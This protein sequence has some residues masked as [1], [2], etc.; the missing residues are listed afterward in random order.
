M[1]TLAVVLA[2]CGSGGTPSTT[3]STKTVTL[4]QTE[5]GDPLPKLDRGWVAVRSRSGGFILGRPPG[6]KP[7][8]SGSSLTLIAP[9]KL[10][11]VTVS[12]DRTPSGLAI[13]TRSF[14]TRTA[15]SL[16]GYKGKLEPSKPRPFR[17]R[18]AA[19]QVVE[20]ARSRD[21]VPQELRVVVM[22]RPRL[23][24]FSAVIARNAKR[25]DAAEAEQAIEIV[26]TVRSRPDNS[27]KSDKPAKRQR[28]A[29][30]KGAGKQKP[31]K[32]S[33]ATKKESG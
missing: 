4:R 27:T 26:G 20:R 12:T 10:V 17:H 8:R 7:K 6:W 23:V 18:Y 25:R 22:R 16:G 19:S 11:A 5:S 33:E 15:R 29:K 3:T 28:S 9:D 30:K 21:G 2:G 32:S 14:A 13:G 1:A 31:A 24:T